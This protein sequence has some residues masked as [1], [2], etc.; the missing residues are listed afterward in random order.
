MIK[1]LSKNEEDTLKIALQLGKNAFS[2]AVVLLTG[3]LGAGK[4]VFVKGLA[5]GLGYNGLV[6]SPT[7]NIMN[8]YDGALPLIHFD[9]YRIANV[10]EFY[11]I[12]GEEYLNN[13]NIC[14]IEWHEHAKGALGAEFLEVI[15]IDEGENERTIKLVAMGMKHKKWLDT[16]NDI[17]N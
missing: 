11:E 4:T 3:D 13:S 10:D 14:A 9:L 5:H 17:N 16:I 8:I 7:Y 1:Y 2:G 6:K 15:L 12:G